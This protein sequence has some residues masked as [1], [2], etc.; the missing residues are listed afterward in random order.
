MQ[1]LLLS[2]SRTS[3]GEY[4]LHALEPSRALLQGRRRAVFIPYAGVTVDWDSY[5]EKVQKALVSLP[6]LVEGIHTKPN[7]KVA[8]QQADVI[9]V[10]GGNT[11]NLLKICREL[12]LLGTIA[13]RVRAGAAY[14]GWSAGAN[15]ACPS[16]CTTN[17]MPIVDPRGFC[18][19]DLIAFQINPHYTNALPEG[20]QG[21]TRNE[22]LEEFLK[23]HPKMHVV[24]LPEGSW[25][26]V[27]NGDARLGGPHAAPWFRAGEEPLICQSGELLPSIA[28]GSCDVPR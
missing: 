4:L 26:E 24:G 15:L 6:L 19:L 7:P 28:A 14:I 18:A 2:N 21:E 12:G 13:E 9:I 20:L 10:G 17:D 1:L 3:T 8:V 5:T 25:L 16:I 27:N 22:R 11:Y 23:V